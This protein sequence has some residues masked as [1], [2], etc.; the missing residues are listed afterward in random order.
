VGEGS[1][2]DKATKKT[3][4]MLASPEREAFLMLRNNDVLGA[5]EI[6]PDGVAQRGSGKSAFEVGIDDD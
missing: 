1:K 4:C 3:T 6:F 5:F 2:P